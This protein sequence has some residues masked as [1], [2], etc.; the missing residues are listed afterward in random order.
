MTIDVLSDAI[1]AALKA[2]KFALPS[3]APDVAVEGVRKTADGGSRPV[4]GVLSSCSMSAGFEDPLGQ[5]DIQRDA[6]TITLIT[7]T[8]PI[9]GGWF[10]TTPPQTGDM[11]TIDDAKYSVF[12]VS[13]SR[14]VYFR[15]GARQC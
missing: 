10:D 14:G 1:D 6:K 15:I 2:V 9:H 4:R 8:S 11:L 3:Q 7:P 5:Y 13:E 12:A